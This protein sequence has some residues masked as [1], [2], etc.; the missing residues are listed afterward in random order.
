MKKDAELQLNF[1]KEK[2]KINF[3][4]ITYAENKNLIN[5]ENFRL[6]VI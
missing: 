4:N 3:L 1:K 6:R 2:N 5:L